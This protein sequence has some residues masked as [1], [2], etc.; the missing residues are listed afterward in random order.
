[1]PEAAPTPKRALSRMRELLR[2][3]MAYRSPHA[4]PLV[5]KTASAWDSRGR[6]KTVAGREDRPGPGEASRSEAKRTRRP[7]WR[8]VLLSRALGARSIRPPAL[9]GQAPDLRRLARLFP[10]TGPDGKPLRWSPASAAALENLRPPEAEAV[11]CRRSARHWHPGPPAFH[12]GG[13]WA[14]GRPEGWA[15]LQK[16][17]KRWWAWTGADQPT[18][19]WHQERWWWRSQ[20]IW[21]MLHQGEAWGYRVFGERRS[22]GLIHPGTGTRMEYSADGERAA[23]ITPGDGAWLF[24]A[25]SG[26]VLHRWTEAQMPRRPKPRAPSAL[27]FPR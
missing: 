14:V 21:F 17:G 7:R 3:I 24:D 4:G 2:R 9:K 22:E 10:K 16:S 12:A 8:P 1:M 23:L 26:A 11:K 20:G 18:W 5:K 25:R 27:S 15:W 19:L 6:P 13:A